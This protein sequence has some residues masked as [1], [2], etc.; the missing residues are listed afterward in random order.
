MKKLSECKKAWKNQKR[1]IEG[2]EYKV[3]VLD[4]SICQKCPDLKNCEASIII[5][6]NK[7]AINFINKILKGGK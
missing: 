4:E 7:R 2:K 1:V 3:Q 6:A 5:A